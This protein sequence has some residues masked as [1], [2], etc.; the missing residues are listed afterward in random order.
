[1]EI[2]IY[3]KDKNVHHIALK[4]HANSK[5]VCASISSILISHLNCI[6][7]FDE[8]AIEYKE[9][10]NL[11]TVSIL[12]Y[13]NT[14]ITILENMLNMFNELKEGFPQDIQTNIVHM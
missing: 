5:I 11:V 9:Q 12:K 13:D 2:N 3:K 1:M 10:E 4:G 6:L 14:T 7:A 8:N